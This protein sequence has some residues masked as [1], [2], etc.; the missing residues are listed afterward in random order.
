MALAEKCI[1]VNAPIDRCMKAWLD[2]PA[3]PCFIKNLERVK[4]QKGSPG[5]WI[6][7]TWTPLGKD[8]DWDVELDNADTTWYALNETWGAYRC[9]FVMRTEGETATLIRVVLEYVP[10]PKAVRLCGNRISLFPQHIMDVDLPRFKALV[11]N[12][13]W[14]RFMSRAQ[15]RQLVMQETAQTTGMQPPSCGL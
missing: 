6:W 8:L 1:R 5:S 2:V 14:S 9:N 4:P 11:E 15:K 7:T 13:V 12:P 3:Y 10:S